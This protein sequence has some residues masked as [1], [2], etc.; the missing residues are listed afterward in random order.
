M[1]KYVKMSVLVEVKASQSCTEAKTVIPMQKFDKQ[2]ILYEI[3]YASH[4]VKSSAQLLLSLL[5]KSNIRYLEKC[6]IHMNYLVFG[7]KHFFCPL[8]Y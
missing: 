3:D 1:E 4:I 8:Q 2:I 6:L 7:R 5:F